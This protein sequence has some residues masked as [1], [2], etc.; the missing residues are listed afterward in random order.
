M[1]VKQPLPLICPLIQGVV[2][3]KLTRESEVGEKSLLWT[4]SQCPTKR[5]TLRPDCRESLSCRGGGAW[6]FP[7][8]TSQALLQQEEGQCQLGPEA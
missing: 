1:S 6:V 8:L 3:V 2:G 4:E 5:R 7:N